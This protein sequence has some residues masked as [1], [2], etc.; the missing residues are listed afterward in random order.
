MVC[1]ADQLLW[2]L[3]ETA[4]LQAHVQIVPMTGCNGTFLSMV[5][6]MKSHDVFC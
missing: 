3:D 2:K 1:K 6:R 5:G 4:V